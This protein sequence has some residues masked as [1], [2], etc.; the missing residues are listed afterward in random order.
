MNSQ[1]AIERTEWPSPGDSYVPTTLT[2]PS[3][4]MINP[5]N[6]PSE[7]TAVPAAA[8]YP[9]NDRPFARISWGA[10]FAGAIIALATQI[11]LAL[12]GMAIGLATLNPAAGDN[13]SG[14]ALGAGAAIWLVVSSLISLFIGGYI[15]ARLAGRFNGW[16]HGLITWGT[17]T[18]LTL[19]LLTTAAGQLIGAASGLS[20]FVVSNSD[21][22]LGLPP[23]LQQQVDQLRTRASQIADQAAAQAQTTDSQTRDAQA[24]D[25]GEKAAKGGAVGTGAAA[26]AMILG[27]IA[28]AMGG[29]AGERAPRREVYDRVDE[30]NRVSDRVER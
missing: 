18:L 29:K 25:A 11:V 26:F 2:N 5:S 6:I 15:A 22:T 27:A 13:P 3:N 24:R 8:T 4:I 16:L 21:K 23:A 7:R 28:A 30:S 14:T 20:N 1:S 10:V 9:F 12:I 17:L 19:T